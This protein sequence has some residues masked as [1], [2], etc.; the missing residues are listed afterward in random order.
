MLLLVLLC[1]LI[2]LPET[3]A[4]RSVLTIFTGLVLMA[5][6]WASRVRG[7]FV[8]VVNSIVLVAVRD[9]HTGADPRGR[10]VHDPERDRDDR[11][12]A[13][14]AGGDRVRPARRAHRQHPDGVR[15][16]LAVLHAGN[17]LRVSDHHRGAIGN[18]ALLRPGK[19]RLAVAARVLQLRDPG[20]PRLRRPHAGHQRGTTAVGAGD[21]HRQPVSG[22][23]RQPG[24]DPARP[25]APT[26]P[27][28]PGRGE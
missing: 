14:D 24:R 9:R 4:G 10:L 20:H 8:R 25:R 7:R 12:H 6:V 13:G 21:D 15:R 18:R 2:L 5:A 11:I 23:R 22:D 1:L 3:T 28:T 27:Q 26:P 17:V 16:D 19:R